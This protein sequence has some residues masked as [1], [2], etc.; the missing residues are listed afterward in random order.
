M[1]FVI[2]APVLAALVASAACGGEKAPKPESALPAAAAPAALPA[3]ATPC[4][5]CKVIEVLATSDEKGNYYSPKEIAANAGDVLRFKIVVGVHNVNFLPDSNPG[6]TGLP[7]ATPLLQL[8]GQTQDIALTFGTGKFYF[9]CDPHAAL[10][11]IGHV[12]VKP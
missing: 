5:T 11:M 10:G 6:R 9:Q 3:T 1:R 2:R 4:A 7:P 12:T 8:P